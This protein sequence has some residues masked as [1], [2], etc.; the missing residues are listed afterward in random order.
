MEQYDDALNVCP[1]CGYVC[2]T[3]AEESIHMQPGTLLH[4]RYI[5]GRVLGYGGFGVTY[6]GWDGK[7]EQKVAIK[8][9]LPGEFSTRM[10]GQ[11]QVTVFNGDKSE[12]FRDGLKK[13]VEESKRLAKFQNEAGIVKI[14]DSFE[15]NETAYIIMEYLDGITLKEYLG[16]V[17]TIPED[18]A[19]NMLMPVM[20]SLQTVH[21]EGL[22][23]RDIAP[24]NIFLTKDGKVTNEWSASEQ[25]VLGVTDPKVQGSFGFNLQWKNFT[26]YTSFL[27]EAGGDRYNSTL[28]TKV[29]GVSIYQSNVDKRVLTDRW[30]TPGQVAKYKRMEPGIYGF[31]ST[32]PTSRFVQK[33]NNLSFSSLTVGYNFDRRLISRMKMSMLRLEAGVNDIF[34]VSSVKRERGLSYPFARSVNFSVQ[35]GF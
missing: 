29:E 33:Y 11:S 28:A 23:H 19:I 13:F 12:Q 17:G 3:P 4:D 35:V 15:E 34:N 10:P 16:Q 8:E 5:V 30:S 27:Y 14:F 7:L 1:H 32:R 6:I 31:T 18:E 26:V 25:Q 21:A 2:G 9:Y 24:D 20:E 22:L